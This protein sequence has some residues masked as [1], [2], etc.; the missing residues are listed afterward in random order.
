MIQLQKRTHHPYDPELGVIAYSPEFNVDGFSSG[1]KK[2]FND[3]R[4]GRIEV[5]TIDGDNSRTTVSLNTGVSYNSNNTPAHDYGDSN[6]VEYSIGPIS[7]TH[8]SAPDSS[9]GSSSTSSSGGD[10]SSP[11][12]YYYR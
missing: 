5:G 6:W 8:V 11:S 1:V 3:A 4:A 12:D 9:S 7:V 10:G 2:L